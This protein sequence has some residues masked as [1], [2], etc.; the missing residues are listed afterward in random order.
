MLIWNVGILVWY[1]HLKSHKGI[2][3]RDRMTPVYGLPGLLIELFLARIYAT[4]PYLKSLIYIYLENQLIY[5]L[6][7]VVV[8]W[9]LSIQS[10][11]RECI[12][13]AEK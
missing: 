5:S 8:K 1:Y 11:L 10:N 3:L 7:K 9:R 6:K 12:S 2:V 4:T 13:S